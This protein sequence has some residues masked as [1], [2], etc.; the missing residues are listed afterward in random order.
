[1]GSFSV[2]ATG[3][4]AMRLTGPAVFGPPRDRGEALGVLRELE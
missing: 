2:S 3:F 4:A 1:L